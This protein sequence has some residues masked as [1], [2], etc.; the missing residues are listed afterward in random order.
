MEIDRS[1]ISPMMQQYLEVKDK[2]KDCV[3]FFRLG[4]FY[5]MFFDDAIEISKALELTLTGRD[6]GLEERAP[7]CG[8]PYHAADM[9]I[10]RLIDMG[11]KVAVCE[12]LTDPA[13]TKGIVVRDVIRVVTPGTLTESSMLDD[14]SNNYICSIFYDKDTNTCGVASADISTGDAA[15]SFFEG[16][17]LEAGVIN[18]LSR[19]RPAEII[20]PENFL[21]L[22]TAADFVKVRLS[23]AVTL[24]DTICFTPSARRDTVT[25]VFGVKSVTE[26][27]ISEDGADCAAVCGLFDYINDTQKTSVSR[28]T[29]IDILNGDQFMGLDLNA[30]RNLE[31]TETLRSKEKKGSLLWVLDS[32]KTSMGRRLLKNWIEQP[33]K[34]PARI[35]ERLDAVEALYRKSVVLA[36]LT[37]LLDRVYDLERLMTKVMYKS[38]N[39]RDLKSLSATAMQ[40]PLIKQELAKL[41][42]SKLLARYNEE[43]STLDELVNLV[44][45]AIIDEPPVSVKDG[46]VI[47][48]GFNKELDD[49]RHIMN[50]G[51]G[52]IDEIEQREKEAT[53]IKNLKIGFNRV[54]GYYLEVT[55][56]YYDLIP[57]GWIRKQTLANAERFITEELKNAE[58]AILGAK[59]KALA[60]EADIFSEVRDFLATKLEPVQK[61]AS[62]VA[63]VDVL[64]SFADVAL[65]NQYIK[66]DIVLDGSID[67][68][69]GR[70]P[71]VELMLTDE[72]FVPND[73]H[74]DNKSDRMSIIT[75]P[76]MSG[77]STYMRQN[78]LIVLMA[79]IGSFVPA[80]S[81]RISVVDKIFTRV[82][83]SDDLTAGQSTFMVEMS[84]VSDIL[85]NATPN[86][87]VILDEVGRGTSTFDGV[88]I[89]R[90]VAEFICNS[91]KLGCKTLFATHYHELIG[92]ENELEGVK[93]YSIAVNKH[94]GTIRFLR[95][96]V[97]GGVDESYGV[98]VAKL[99]GLPAKV[100][101]RARELLEEMEKAHGNERPVVKNDD[102]GQIS[103]GSLGREAA[104]DMLEKTNIDELSDSEC[105]ELLKDMLAALQ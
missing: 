40:L 9:Y 64:C 103:F 81:A 50:N 101:A 20:F 36:D 14:G 104:L 26:L 63:S 55:R 11:F 93:N 43:I 76:N 25:E 34:S 19:C 97:R 73:L 18:E 29:A 10:K 17:D 13:E 12:Q 98:D 91:K 27:G 22:K 8:I 65:R 44:E 67:I 71:V 37:D 51:R 89:A 41:S 39:P 21:S 7:M 95:K 80:D 23:C 30:R 15:L 24:R 62:A 57:E 53:G 3:L 99:A 66:P 2:Y 56:S 46:G 78:A 32:T 58:N 59:D 72:V 69:A 84:E 88:S 94:G 82:G 33:L 74:I 85:K 79:Q 47:K 75:G 5:E 105:R 86:S 77:K 70:H 60:L 61:T 31:L 92:L 35:I 49:L 68:K 28:F 83:A 1:K 52:I 102:F 4:D 48:E 90:A 16:K 6:C 38:A 54:F 96:I 45:N 42:D 100:V 87:L